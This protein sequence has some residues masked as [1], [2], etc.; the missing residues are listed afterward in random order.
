MYKIIK[1][2]LIATS[3]IITLNLAGHANEQTKRVPTPLTSLSK[4]TIQTLSDDP[5]SFW[6]ES[7]EEKMRKK[8]RNRLALA[9]I[10]APL[11]GLGL[12][13]AGVGASFLA[14]WI[15]YDLTTPREKRDLG[16]IVVGL[17]GIIGGT[18]MGVGLVM[19]F[20]GLPLMIIGLTLA[21]ITKEKIRAEFGMIQN[22]QYQLSLAIKL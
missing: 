7:P 9:I 4:T 3:L 12:V 15:H 20:A 19:T 14:I 13:S 1:T 17:G 5:N 22:N 21:S 16:A 10:G 11:M 8:Y 2:I 18:V 6:Y